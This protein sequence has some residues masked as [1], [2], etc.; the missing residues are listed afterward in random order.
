MASK[1]FTISMNLSQLTFDATRNIERYDKNTRE[2]IQ[3]VIRR[4][5]H[6]ALEEATRLAPYGPTGNLK[7]GITE[8]FKGGMYARGQVKSTAP[9]SHLVEFGS[10]ERI[11]YPV[12][13][14]ALKFR[15]GGFAKGDIYNGKMPKAPFMKPAA[16]KVKPQIEREMEEVLNSDNRT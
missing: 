7:A 9:H 12:K 10:G 8:D 6:A 3:G 14:Q 16:E 4:G 5:T 13:K 1:G 2:A 15:D 11:V